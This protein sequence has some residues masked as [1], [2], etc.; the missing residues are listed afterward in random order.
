M[1]V[2][3][4]LLAAALTLAALSPAHATAEHHYGKR[5]YAVIKDGRAPNGRLA[6]AAHGAGEFGNDDFHLYLMAGPRRLAALGNVSSDNNLDTAPAAYFA[7]WSPDSRYVA[8]SFRSERHI[9][10][11]N[12]YVIEGSRARLIAVPDL[13]KATTGRAVNIKEDGDMRTSVPH[14]EWQGAGR[15]RLSDYRLFV[16]DDA[17]LADKLGDLGKTTKMDDG[18]SSI[19]FSA[20]AD[21]TLTR[22][23]KFQTGKVSAGNFPAS[24]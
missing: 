16:E 17:A 6:I 14:L 13:F 11:L 24:E 19:E 10:T 2:R 21:V 7:A 15:F 8:V 18:R 3:L 9:V 12:L 1:L 23:D 4:A 20:E 5:E 22:R